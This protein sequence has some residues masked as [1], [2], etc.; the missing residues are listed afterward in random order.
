MEDEVKRRRGSKEARLARLIS[1]V[2]G[3]ALTVQAAELRAQE[4]ETGMA[5][6]SFLVG[7][8]LG[9]FADFIDP[10]PGVGFFG[11][12][13][14]DRRGIFGLRLDGSVLLYGR[15]TTQRPLS[16]T[17]QRVQVDV[18]TQ[19][20]IFSLMFGPQFT[21]PGGPVRPYANAAI[22]FSYFST[23]SSVKGTSDERDFASSTNFEDGTFAWAAGGGLL[24]RLSRKVSLDLSG[25]YLGNGQ[26]RYLREGSIIESATGSISFTPIESETDLLLL[27]AGVSLS[28]GKGGEDDQGANNM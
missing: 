27:Q 25:R 4:G 14:V 8:P 5:G 13:N 6:L 11:Q 2:L 23:T 7:V 22:G 3:L 26:V 24:I 21:V 28:F 9:D 18:T 20:T 15:E 16:L 1:L 17:V 10:S 12:Y 19:N